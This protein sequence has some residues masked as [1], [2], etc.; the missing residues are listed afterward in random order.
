MDKEDKVYL[1]FRMDRLRIDA[2]LSVH[3]FVAFATL[4][5]IQLVDKIHVGE[6]L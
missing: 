3:G 6:L 4:G 2:A 1:M 5:S